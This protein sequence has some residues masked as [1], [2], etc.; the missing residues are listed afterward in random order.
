MVVNY[1]ST[2]KQHVKLKLNVFKKC[3]V[4][5]DKEG[6]LLDY[7]NSQKNEIQLGGKKI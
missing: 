7:K 2:T 1:Y 3:D 4:F 6:Y 5:E